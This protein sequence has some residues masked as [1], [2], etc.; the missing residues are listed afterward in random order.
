M[1]N[2]AMKK[3]THTLFLHKLDQMIFPTFARKTKRVRGK[4]METDADC[5]KKGSHKKDFIDFIPLDSHIY[6]TIYIY[7]TYNM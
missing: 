6:I 4:K 1:N 2:D 3:H 7:D 5:L